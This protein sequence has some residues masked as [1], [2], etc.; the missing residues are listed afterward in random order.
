MRTFSPEQL[1][2]ALDEIGGSP[3]PDYLDDI[4]TQAGRTRQRPAW[5]FPERWIQM[6]IALRPAAIP[7]AFASTLVVLAAL[8]ALLLASLLLAGASPSVPP[9][10][11][12]H[13]GL[14]AF[15]GSDGIDV[16]APDGSAKRVLI[17]GTENYAPVWSPDG[18]HLA[19]ESTG[20][21]SAWQLIVVNADGSQPVN[22]AT[23]TQ[24]STSATVAWSP[25]GQT[26]AYSV[27]T[28]QTGTCAGQGTYNGDFCTSRI[29][30]AAVD[31]SGSRPIG[32]PTLDARSPVWS[33]NGDLI[34]FGGGNASQQVH[35]Y[36]MDA[37]GTNVHQVGVVTGSDWAFLR[38]AWSS[39]GSMIAAQAGKV[40]NLSATDIWTI[41][42]NGSAAT[43]VGAD[44]LLPTWAPDRNALA[45]SAGAGIVL[46]DVDGSPVNL[47][48]S[49][50]FPTWSPDG[51]LLAVSDGTTL[52]V[53]GMDGVI[54]ASIPGGTDK[55]SW[56]RLTAMP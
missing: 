20:P 9:V 26:I 46:M 55:S 47:P 15:D 24:G 42:V 25:N 48:V 23:A 17:P 32:D 33:P 50:A 18:T 35:L 5:T 40:G 6:T 52:H 8:L 22:V 39:D 10:P 2:A 38:N 16:A 41:P 19:Y 11:I 4:V 21:G 43:D 34:A 37:D 28:T 3:R 36:V 31:G 54:H 49:G 14:I 44:S 13:N 7:R 53:V 27:P 30:L 51:T 45:W 29:F 12:V 56:Q 1:T